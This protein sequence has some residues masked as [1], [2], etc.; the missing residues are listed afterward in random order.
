M[1]PNRSRAT[2]AIAADDHGEP[3]RNHVDDDEDPLDHRDPDRDPDTVAS[4]P[5]ALLRRAVLDHG[6]RRDSRSS[7]QPYQ[8]G[9]VSQVRP[10][11]RS[12]RRASAAGG[13]VEEEAV[14]DRAGAADVGPERA[15]LLE[16]ARRAARRRGRS[17]EARRGRAG[18]SRRGERREQCGAA[19]GEALRAVAR[20]EGVVDGA[21]RRLLGAVR[22]DED[23]PVVLRQVERRR[24]SLP[25]PRAELRALREEERDVGA[26]RRR[27]ARRGGRAASGSASSAFASAKRG[28]R[29]GAAAA[30][31]GRDGDA[32]CRSSPPSSARRP[33]AAA[34]A[35]SA[36]PTIVSS[37]KPATREARGGLDARCGR[38]ARCAAGRWR[39]RACRRARSGP[40]TSARLIFAAR[41]ARVHRS[42]S[43]RRDELG[44]RERLGPGRRR[45]A[46][47]GE[48]VLR[49][50]PRRDPGELRASS[51]ASCA[52][53]RTRPRRRASRSRSGRAA[54]AAERDERRVDVRAAAG[55]PSRETGWKPVLAAASW[56]STETAPYAFVDGD[57]EEAVGDLALHH[58]APE[59]D[60]RQ[61]VEALDDHGV[62][63]LYGQVRDELRRR[64]SRRGEVERERVAAVRG[65]RWRGR[66]AA[67][68]A[69]ARAS[70]SS[71]TA[72][73]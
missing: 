56:T 25:S 7:P 3:P 28:R 49:V 69:A 58:H 65:R 44:G 33:A 67:R 57:G 15:S 24:A 26:D 6:E 22:E 20:V 27:R 62:A 35:A 51:R 48:R 40:T 43:A 36:S 55:R 73:T 54:D 46:E 72:C 18:A 11:P 70:W 64:R 42:A 39:P 59:L 63:T 4:E 38:R 1:R 32:S 52:G 14:D 23:D 50:R 45:A 30:E 12:A 29:V 66:R 17:R 71:S 2:T 10:R 13:A 31:P 19:L 16:L 37:A 60:R 21:G 61:A 8:A 53:A 68:G 9:T 47:R 34:S 5:A 41:R